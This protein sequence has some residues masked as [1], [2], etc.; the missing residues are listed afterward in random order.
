MRKDLKNAAKIVSCS[1]IDTFAR[2]VIALLLKYIQTDILYYHLNLKGDTD[3]Q[4]VM[5]NAIYKKDSAQFHRLYAAEEARRRREDLEL[6]E[7]AVLSKDQGIMAE[8][9]AKAVLNSDIESIRDLTDGGADVDKASE[10]NEAPLHVGIMNIEKSLNAI[11]ELLRN[12]ADTNIEDADGTTVAMRA[13]VIGDLEILKM[14]VQAGTDFSAENSQG[15]SPMDILHKLHPK[16][17]S[18]FQDYI[19]SLFNGDPGWSI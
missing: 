4:D 8:L 18:V 14:L 9:L 15:I 10:G 17:G 16:I 5:L 6:L 7:A 11:K 19:D 1:N 13:V 2:G 3:M 12:G